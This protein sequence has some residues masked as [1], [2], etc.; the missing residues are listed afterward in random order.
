[1]SVLPSGW[2]AESVEGN[3][4]DGVDRAEVV[5]TALGNDSGGHSW[6]SLA[7]VPHR[8][9]SC[10]SCHLLSKGREAMDGDRI[11]SH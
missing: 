2:D 7:G 4:W 3:G 11:T 8:A 1:M 6:T 10:F 5:L 9:E